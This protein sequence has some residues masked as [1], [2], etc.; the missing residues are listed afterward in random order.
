MAI[1]VSPVSVTRTAGA[2]L[3]AKQF[4]FVEQA[5]TGKVTVNNTLGEYSLGVLQ[6]AP[7]LNQE[8]QVAVAG[9][10]KVIAG[11]TLVPGDLVNVSA[12]G[13]AVVASSTYF[14]MGEVLVGGNDGQIV[15]V[16]LR[17]VAQS[18]TVIVTEDSTLQSATV[19]VSSAELLA[20]NATP[21][22]LIAAPGAGYANVVD[23]AVLFLDYNSAAYDGVAGGEDLEIR[24]TN[25][26]GQLLNTIETTGFLTAT[27]DQVRYVQF[28][29]ATYITPVENAAVVL[30]LASGEI[31]TGNSPLKV[32][33][34]YR[35]VPTAL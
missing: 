18:G 16:L 12:A 6:N 34:Y 24:Y 13:K 11:G 29:S 1:E 31:A 30:D 27:S 23:S 26:S 19:T 32:K 15:S 2:D 3:S 35:V 20:L 10:V 14:I 28:G 17:P 21:K 22:T 25:G 7:G 9:V 33:I 5:S 8:A 4:Y